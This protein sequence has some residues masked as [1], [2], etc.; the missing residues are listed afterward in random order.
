MALS[1]STT[2]KKTVY[3]KISD[4]ISSSLRKLTDAQV[5]IFGTQTQVLRI[6]KVVRTRTLNNSQV[7]SVLGDYGRE[8]EAT[9]L[10]SVY[11]TYPFNDLEIFTHKDP[12]ASN[13]AQ[14]EV[15]LH[16]IDVTDILPITM[17]ILFEGDYD[18]DPIEINPDDLIVDLKFDDKNNPI[19]IVMDVKR[20][21]GSFFGKNQ[22]SK[23]CE[24]SMNRNPVST[25]I[26]LAINDYI[27]YAQDVR[28]E[29]L[30]L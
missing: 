24:L 22:V 6:T 8:L 10:H 19:P 21:R 28:R 11:I 12:K 30:G 13:P 5:K 9:V 20:L 2:Y 3:D 18:L 26:Q 17:T 14:A 4:G 7:V 27:D 15:N 23:R 16:G 29:E 1:F 25:G